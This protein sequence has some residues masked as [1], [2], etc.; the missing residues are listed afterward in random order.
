MRKLFVA[1]LATGLAAGCSCGDTDLSNAEGVL[2]FSPK[3][4]DF[5]AV[6][7]GEERELTID[8]ANNGRSDVVL[9]FGSSPDGFTAEPT[10]LTLVPGATDVVTVT[11]APE[12][13]GEIRGTLTYSGMSV[14][15]VGIGAE[16]AVDV[17]DELDFG[18]VR[19]GETKTLPLEITNLAAADVTAVGSLE[20]S[21]AAAFLAEPSTVDLG[22]NGVKSVEVTFA[23]P[24]RG[25]HAAVFK[26]KLCTDCAETEIRLRGNGAVEQVDVRPE[27]C[28]FGTVS[29]G[30]SATKELRVTN[31]GDL[32]T[33]IVD[34]SFLDGA[35]STFTLEE[36]IPQEGV[37]LDGGQAESFH[38]VFTPT[39]VGQFTA[40]VRVQVAGQLILVP[41][42]GA[43]GSA[44]LLAVPSGIDFGIQSPGS[45]VVRRVTIQNVGEPS[46]VNLLNIG[47]QGEDTT[48]FAYAEDGAWP[49]AQAGGAQSWGVDVTFNAGATDTYA[50]EL[51]L[52]TDDADEPELRIPLTGRI[53]DGQPCEI[54]IRPPNV[55]FGFVHATET[56]TRDVEIF[57]DGFDDCYVWGF[58]LAPDSSTAFTLPNAPGDVVGI[59][60]GTSLA[61]TVQYAPPEPNVN[62]DEGV[63]V[64]NRVHPTE[65]EVQIPLSGFPSVADVVVTPNPVDF[66][67]QPIGLVNLR[68]VTILNQGERPIRL[69]ATIDDVEDGPPSIRLTDDTSVEF[70]IESH[71]PLPR[72]IP[73]GAQES[74]HLRWEAAN[75]GRD[76]GQLEIWLRGAVAPIIVDL[77]AEGSNQPCG[78]ACEAPVASCPAPTTTW[79]ATSVTLT[80]AGVDPDGDPVTC[81]WIPI[82]APAGSFATLSEPFACETQ[83]R[84]DVPGD[85]DFE[86]VVRDPQGNE[87]RCQTRVTA[88]VYDGLWIETTWSSPDDLDLHLF[89]PDAGDILDPATWFQLPYDCYYSNQAPYWDEVG[90][91]D[92]PSLDRDDTDGTGPENARIDQPSQLHGYR[93]GV[94]WFRSSNGNRQQ[95]VTTNVYC[96]GTLAA[97]VVNRLDFVYEAADVGTVQYTSPNTCTFTPG[98]WSITVAP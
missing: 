44:D 65:P 71:F 60:P 48:A 38:V 82:N 94:H 81:E 46:P 74:I 77:Y 17:V 67:L 64:F 29:P 8:V 15:V 35:S 91:A 22:P 88:S 49:F 7:V 70:A 53:I 41:C 59:A 54:S 31:T 93:I 27:T 33:T 51:V 97:S 4:L 52:V 11:F 90:R 36:T 42:T 26:L 47:I 72:V 23:P 37:P 30:R 50:A 12:I 62:G 32:P 45:P 83:F 69:D 80:G 96:G 84:P 5:G 56:F 18:D 58:G 57:N 34:V 85:Y 63:M 68:S 86:L 98:R 76:V 55:R 13:L 95:D 43:G 75:I 79:T 9:S 1:V 3:S 40:T 73:S 2:E 78:A 92:D 61:V 16:R 20:G 14:P 25:S 89:H 6:F 28:D 39:D 21:D 24:A 10:E 19:V 66:G 87:D